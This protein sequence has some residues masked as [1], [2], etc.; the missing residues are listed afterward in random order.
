MTMQKFLVRPA[1]VHVSDAVRIS[2]QYHSFTC[3]RDEARVLTQR[4]H[5][6]GGVKVRRKK[7]GV[8][9]AAALG[10]A[11]L[12]AGCG[13]SSSSGGGSGSTD[14]SKAT[15]AAGG[16]MAALVKAAEKEGSLT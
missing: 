11:V 15:S 1:I 9:I 3:P 10:C 2:G 8:A 16:G 13:S 6:G 4:G 12:A 7:A 14:W 5:A